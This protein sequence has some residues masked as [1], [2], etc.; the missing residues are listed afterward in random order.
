M[1]SSAPSLSRRAALW[2]LSLALLGLAASVA[3]AVVHY[4]LLADPL[5]RSVCDFN[6]TWSCTQVYESAYGA[7]WGVP[8]AVGGV[9]W[10]AAVT[11]LAIVGLRGAGTS[12]SAG[13][14]SGRVAG[15]IFALSIVG[16][17]AVLY[18]GYASL[19]VLKT[20]CLFCFIT[21]FAVTGLFLVSGAAADGTMTGLP[22]RALGDLRALLTSPV[23]LGLAV[24]FGVGAIAL[25][26]LF[27]RQVDAVTAAAAASAPVRTL[28]AAEQSNFEQWYSSLPRVPLAVPT[29]GAKVLIV[30]FNDYQCPPCRMTWEQYKPVIAK[31]MAQYPGKVKF[32]TKDY[33]LDGECNVNTPGAGHASACE[34][35]VAVRL[36][37]AKGR[38]EAME[39]W[40]FANQPQITPDL[41]KQ[42]ARNIGGITDFDA[43]YAKTLELVKADI[44]LGASLKVTGTPTFFV[45]GAR[46]PIVKP[47]FFDAA[48]AYEL[49]H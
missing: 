46:V 38:A 14:L 48:I 6:D 25:V 24:A 23:A 15:Y 44:A 28:E 5:Y 16:L 43:Q 29:D 10:F 19:F 35:A 11:L 26:A 45:N 31:Y 2:L 49:K 9:V 40:L 12:G 4:Q 39:E 34:A 32:V 17:S 7:F 41:V 27:P 30:K 33:P 37:R 21:Y 36:A 42:G 3:A 13:A 1:T 18:L 22:R 8:V 20:Y 47:E